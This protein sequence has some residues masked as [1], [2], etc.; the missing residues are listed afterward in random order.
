MYLRVAQTRDFR[1]DRR[2]IFQIVDGHS[3]WQVNGAGQEQIE[4]VSTTYLP[5]HE[6]WPERRLARIFCH[7]GELVDNSGCNI[8]DACDMRDNHQYRG[9]LL[10]SKTYGGYCYQ[11]IQLVYLFRQRV[12]CSRVEKWYRCRG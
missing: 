2:E 6:L 10:S 3:E 8:E 9:F 4:Y 5:L 1:P 7:V 11:S 12:R